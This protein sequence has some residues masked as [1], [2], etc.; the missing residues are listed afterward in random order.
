MLSSHIWKSAFYKAT[1]YSCGCDMQAWLLYIL[2]PP[3]WQLKPLFSNFQPENIQP[4][5]SVFHMRES[6]KKK[7][8]SDFK[9]LRLDQ[10]HD[11]IK[12]SLYKSAELCTC[13][14]FERRS[15]ELLSP[16]TAHPWQIHMRRNKPPGWQ[17][18]GGGIGELRG[19]VESW[20]MY[21]SLTCY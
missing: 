1:C 12:K 6:F 19:T 10:H 20:G 13:S 16:T 8:Q 2:Y 3:Q 17:G 11:K 14:D 18:V 9:A 7:A 5:H 21:S 15:S 4:S